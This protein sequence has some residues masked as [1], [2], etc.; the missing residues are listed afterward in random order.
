MELMVFGAWPRLFYICPHFLALGLY[1][2]LPAVDKFLCRRWTGFYERT[3]TRKPGF[4]YP[5]TRVARFWQG[6]MYKK[7]L[8]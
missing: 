4:C 1:P 2:S 8:S 3:E 6:I 7:F 5:Q